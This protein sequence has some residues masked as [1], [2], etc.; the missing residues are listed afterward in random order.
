MKRA[1]LCL[2]TSAGGR[3]LTGVR[4]HAKSVPLST[5]EVAREL[6]GRSVKLVMHLAGG[7]GWFGLAMSTEGWW[8][9]QTTTHAFWRG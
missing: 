2:T 6:H 4:W 7:M 8:Q 9:W 1:Q 5:G 3:R